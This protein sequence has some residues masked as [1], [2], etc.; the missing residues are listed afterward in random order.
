[1]FHFARIS[2]PRTYRLV[3]NVLGAHNVCTEIG[4]NKG[5][6]AK[7]KRQGFYDTLWLRHTKS[8]PVAYKSVFCLAYQ[9]GFPNH[10]KKNVDGKVS[11]SRIRAYIVLYMWGEY[12]IDILAHQ[13]GKNTN[14]G[15]F[16][17]VQFANYGNK[18]LIL[19]S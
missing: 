18:S 19:G 2:A 1:M 15:H 14:I 7:L 5:S 13:V 8:G 16:G 6:H 17:Y 10:F 4:L 9:H 12:F 11:R 3:A